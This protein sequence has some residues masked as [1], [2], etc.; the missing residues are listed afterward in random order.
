MCKNIVV[1]FGGASCENEISIITGAMVCNVLK[2]GGQ[3]VY[4]VYITQ[5]GEF[6]C[7]DCLADIKNYS[8]G[9]IPEAPRAA[10]EKGNLL[11]LSKRGKIKERAPVYC[12]LNCCHGG[13]GEGGGIS[14]L[15]L[16]MS[17]PL[18]SA[19]VFESSALMDKY[20]TKI[21]LK[22][23]GVPAVEYV[24]LRDISGATAIKNFPVIV[25]PARLGSSIGVEKADNREELISALKTAFE[26]DSAAI[27][28]R[29]IQNR[30]E[31][32]C[33]AYA[34]GGEV[35]T[36]PCEE[37]FGG[38]LLS[39]DD[40][41]SGSGRRAFPADLQKDISERIR[42]ITKNVYSALGMRGIVRFDFILEGDDIYVSE[43][44]T[45]PG[46]LSQYLLSQN[47]SAFYKLLMAL[48]DDARKEHSL[49][50]SKLLI[51]TGIINNFA[52]NAC[53]IK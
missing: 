43:I 50:N 44:N 12:A 48:I 31:I 35:V 49:N 46:S 27:V 11:V 18:A 15:C 7:A 3:K 10:F 29:Y 39:Y 13:W 1:F 2:N 53:K 26:L 34:V 6:F 22:G 19:G 45:V 42:G 36:S 47:Y 17:L 33:A 4:P 20:L 28:E 8:D 5:G 51:N 23:L 41:Y 40:K 21:I 30:R 25:K 16:S 14:G 37:V 52:S 32:N 38:S 9:R 24:Y